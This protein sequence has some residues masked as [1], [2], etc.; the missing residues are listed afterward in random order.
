MNKTKVLVMGLAD[1]VHG[2]GTKKMSE[3]FKDFVVAVFP[4][5]KGAT[6]SENKQM[7]DAFEK[8]AKVGKIGFSPIEKH[9]PLATK[10]KKMQMPD[11]IRQRIQNS[12]RKVLK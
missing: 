6:T 3:A 10:A 2:E 11:D 4:F 12:S 1:V 5:V 9:N 8:E 7:L